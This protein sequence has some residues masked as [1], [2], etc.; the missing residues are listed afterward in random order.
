MPVTSAFMPSGETVASVVN[1]TQFTV[2]TGTG[3][4]AGT[5]ATTTLGGETVVIVGGANA[6]NALTINAPIGNVGVG[7]S[8]T[9]A[10]N[11]TLILGGDNIYTGNT[12]INEGTVQL[13]GASATLG[14]ITTPA[15]VTT[16]RQGTT[17]DINAAGPADRSHRR[18]WPAQA[19]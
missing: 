17:L 10:G 11:G 9:K 1:S 12:N 13:S 14:L 15:N 6:A 16:L 3:V 19:R 4:P 8:L 18:R 2:S 7:E 5:G